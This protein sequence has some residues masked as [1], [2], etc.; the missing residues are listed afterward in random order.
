[1]KISYSFDDNEKKADEPLGSVTISDGKA[2]LVAET[3]YLD[4]FF[5]ALTTA[6][7]RS[8]AERTSLVELNSE[9]EPITIE[10]RGMGLLLK[11]GKNEVWIS[12][13]TEFEKELEVACNSLLQAFS[14]GTDQ[15]PDFGPVRN[16]LAR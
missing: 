3:V 14:E 5:S 12:S 9:P 1:M 16:F 7:T 8:A 4:D 6:Y 10:R 13:T 2:Q 11:Y 15:N